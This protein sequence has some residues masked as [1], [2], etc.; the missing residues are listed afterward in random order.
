MHTATH[1]T[2]S[3]KRHPLVDRLSRQAKPARR[4]QGHRTAHQIAAGVSLYTDPDGSKCA[5]VETPSG[6]PVL[7]D[8]ADLERILDAGYSP[9]FS[10]LCTGSAPYVAT[11]GC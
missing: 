10:L 7:I 9:A 6:R 11:R 8:L 1:T 5:K 2:T 3:A 4:P